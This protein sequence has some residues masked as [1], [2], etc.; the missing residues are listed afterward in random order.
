[1]SDWKNQLRYFPC[2]S[3]VDGN[4]TCDSPD[5]GSP[6]KHPLNKGWQKHATNDSAQ[7]EKWRGDPKI[8]LAIACGRASN[9]FVLDVDGVYGP[10]SVAELEKENGLL[11]ET[12]TIRTGNGEQR[13][14]QYPDT[15]LPNSVKFVQ[16]LDT[17]SDGGYVIAEGARHKSGRTYTVIKDVPPAEMPAW[18]IAAVQ[19]PHGKNNGKGVAVP[20][21]GLQKGNRN[22]TIFK[23]AASLHHKQF[24]I[25]AAR[26]ACLEENKHAAQPLPEAE[27]A[28]AVMSAYSY[29]AN[30][31]LQVDFWEDQT[32]R[33]LF[34]QSDPPLKY[35]TDSTKWMGY[36]NG[37][38]IERTGPTQEIG[39]FLRSL[40]PN[41]ITDPKLA[42]RVCRR[43]NSRN[44]ASAVEFFSEGHSRLSIGSQ[45]FDPD[46][47]LL[48]LPG[49]D[50]L[51]L[52]TGEIR[53]ATRE[54]LITRLMPVRPAP[55]GEKCERWGQYFDE[56]HGS[57]TETILFLQQWA[58]LCLTASKIF[59][60]LLFL[61]GRAGAGKGTF[62]QP[63]QKLLGPYATEV[64]EAMLLDSTD[65]ARRDN[66]LADLCGRRLAVCG[67]G[68]KLKRLDMTLFKKL[69]GGDS[70]TGR[71]MREQPI[72]FIPTH[73]MVISSNSEP[74]LELD[75]G[76]KRRVVV[77]PFDHVPAKP[78]Q[79]LREWFCEPPQLALIFRWALDGLASLLKAGELKTPSR[80]TERTEQYFENA[81]L[82]GRWLED[83]TEEGP[84]SSHFAS[85]TELFADWGQYYERENPNDRLGIGAQR[86]FVAELEKRKPDLKQ[87]RRT[88]AGGKVRGFSGIKLLHFDQEK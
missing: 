28:T 3:I 48:G 29:P 87:D 13:Y 31:E 84:G 40:I 81:D 15:S 59:D 67:E 7:I 64:S 55:E 61:I 4:C 44:A 24:S 38:W 16:D 71:R 82:M 60:I 1:M 45:E 65:A 80:G 6:G 70:I 10:V 49:G 33:D 77:I 18:L 34:V 2:H 23:L 63:L 9:I 86:I 52:R 14:F 46:Q 72:T 58:G 73:K 79:G 11:P 19:K 39:D 88:F 5:C 69:S 36:S 83:R 20:E 21:G 8:N 75:D 35:V 54:D 12:Y 78:E 53:P 30:D 62:L 47:W 56:A 22:N 74:V 85:T 27:V 68:S 50:V 25:E 32:L 41:N 76:M 42:A 37:I 26:A 51:D 66:Y 17:R 57:D 43:L